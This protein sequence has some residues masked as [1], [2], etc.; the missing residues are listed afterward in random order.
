MLCQVLDER[1]WTKEKYQSPESII[2]MTNI[3]THKAS[4]I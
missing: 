3:M 4:Y 2:E 1:L